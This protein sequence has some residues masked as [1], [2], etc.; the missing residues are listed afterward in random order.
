MNNNEHNA[1]LG[2]GWSFPP[3]FYAHNCEVVLVAHEEDIKQSLHVLLSTKPG[4][5]LMHPSFGCNLKHMV[6][7]TVTESVITKIRDAI[8]RAIL[9]FEA[10]ITLHKVTVNT[11]DDREQPNSIYDGVMEISLDYTIRKTNTRSNMVFPFYFAEADN[12]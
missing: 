8:E 3:T 7:E 1:F 2:S 12:I 5:R 11:E 4:E 9:F 10:R 6:F